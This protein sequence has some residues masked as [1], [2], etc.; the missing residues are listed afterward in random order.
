MRSHEIDYKIMGESIQLV[1]V[2]LD[3]QETVI[4]EAGAMV[5]MEEGIAFETRLGDGSEPN[6]N[7][8]GKLFSAG[9]RALTGES[10]FMTHF[11]N[12]GYGK[13]H[14]AF[15]APYPGTIIPIDLQKSGNRLIVQKDGFLCAALGTQISMQFNRKLGAGLVG[16]EGFILQ[17]LEGDGMA[18]VHAGGTVIE[19]QLNNE[20][21]R[22]DTGCIVAFESQIDFD[23]ETS[24]SLKSMVF[25]GEGLF[26]ATLRGTGR[27]WLQSM[28]ISKL[29]RAISPHGNNTGKESRSILGGLLEG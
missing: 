16:G 25:G 15:A 9:A 27:V 19:K 24:G 8:L 5:Y 4:A 20:V 23:V 14:V 28:P 12:R 26:L 11:T 21:L 22:I 1:E 2:E 18:F 17:R 7:F 10:I 6:Q 29:I 3:P 13:R